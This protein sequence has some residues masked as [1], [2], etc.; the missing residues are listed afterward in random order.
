MSSM[1]GT[2]RNLYE[3][4]WPKTEA[5][6]QAELGGNAK[7]Q[8]YNLELVT[9]RVPK[10]SVVCDIGG[11]WGAFAASCTLAGMKAILIDDFQDQGFFASADPRYE[12]VRQLAIT[13]IARDA[14]RDGIDFADNSIDAFTSFDS[15]EHWHASPKK[16]FVQVMKALRPGGLFLLGVPNCTNLRKRLEMLIGR[17]EWSAMNDWYEQ[18]VFRGHVREPNVQDLRYIG[19]ELGLQNIEITGRNWQGYV[20]SG[21][22]GRAAKL[23]D[24]P[25]RLRPSLCSD[26]YLIG[27]KAQ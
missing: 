20:Q 8:A 18:E 3:T 27:R 5:Y 12:M 13:V 25:L 10:G 14:V 22:V 17:A 1:E 2:I 16:L 24:F 19:R 7:R 15:M 26:I 11:G 23:F 6:S 4:W 21:I 9:E